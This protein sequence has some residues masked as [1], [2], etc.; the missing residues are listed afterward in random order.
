[1]AIPNPVPLVFVVKNG[2][3]ARARVSCVIPL[4]VSVTQRTTLSWRDFGICLTIVLVSRDVCRFYGEL[5][6]IGHCVTRID[7]KIDDG[8]FQVVDVRLDVPKPSTSHRLDFHTLADHQA[9]R[10]AR[11]FNRVF[12]RAGKVWAQ[13]HDRRAIRS[14]RQLR[15]VLVYILQNHRKHLPSKEAAVSLDP[16][17]SAYW[18]GGFRRAG[19]ELAE[20]AR[21][22]IARVA[23]C[24]VAPKTWLLAD[25]WR[26]RGGGAIHPREAPTS[27]SARSAPPH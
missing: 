22:P 26:V 14:P 25:G 4:P 6:T 11:A 24:V 1:M 10:F 15:N 9:I 20:L 7:R 27:R 18:F 8:G 2:S 16:C 5:A 21:S 12:A 19:P 17:S 3:N 23:K 13:R